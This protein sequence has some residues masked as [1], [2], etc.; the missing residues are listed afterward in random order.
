[1]KTDA[2]IK[3]DVQDELAWEPSID[4][5]QIGVTVRD[6]IVTLSGVVDNYAKKMAAEKA[7]KSVKGVKAV[8]EDIVVQYGIRDKKT[9]AEI[10]KAALDALRWNASI[11]NDTVMIKV[12]EGWVYLS[13]ELQ[14]EYQKEAAR[15]ALLDLTGVKGVVNSIAL[16]QTIKP[17]EIHDRI[18]KAFERSADLDANK[19]SI[20]VDG[21][22]ITLTGTVHSIK[23]K[24]D[25]RRA[26]FN[27]PGVVEVKNNLRV[28]F[29]SEYAE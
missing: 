21:H 25:A 2:E 5:T 10:A 14:W 9:D 23:E 8:A 3:Q 28:D 15:N 18:A 13:G 12:E 1:M 27:S 24:E 7:A 20:Q 22:T 4:E 16:K 26:A 29:Y 19:I 6:G 11:P 17:V